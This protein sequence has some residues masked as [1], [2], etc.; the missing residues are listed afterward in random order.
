M[1]PTI[2]A[3]EMIAVNRIIMLIMYSVFVMM[4]G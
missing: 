2:K 1:N 4:Q 3:G